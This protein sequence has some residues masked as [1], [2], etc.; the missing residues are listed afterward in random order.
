MPP[1]FGQLRPRWNVHIVGADVAR[2]FVVLV[3]PARGNGAGSLGSNGRLLWKS[4][5]KCIHL[6]GTVVIESLDIDNRRDPFAPVLIHGFRDGASWIE[7]PH[8]VFH[9][10]GD[11]RA[12]VRSL[13][14]LLVANGPDDYT[15]MI[16]VATDHGLELLQALCARRHHSRLIHR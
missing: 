9:R 1:I 8:H 12:G 2:F 11:A 3:D 5:M 15:G 13:K 14:V 16:T 4:P 6:L 7:P 10:F